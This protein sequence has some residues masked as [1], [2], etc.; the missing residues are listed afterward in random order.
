MR[1][2]SDFNS[3]HS[4]DWPEPEKLRPYF[5]SSPDTRWFFKTGN[6]SAFLAMEGLSGT[7]HLLSG[8]GRIDVRLEMY[9]HPELGILLYYLKTGSA[10]KGAFSSKGDLSR[11]REWVRTL[12]ND[13]M[14]VGLFISYEKA[15]LAV[16]EFIETDGALPKS[17]EWIA[18]KD[19]PPGTFPVP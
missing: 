10:D 2:R 13:P 19:L 11:L 8:A 7:D 3:E 5:L 17:I 6:D 16:K 4:F 9:G 18:N 14:P 1:K 12:H 15:W